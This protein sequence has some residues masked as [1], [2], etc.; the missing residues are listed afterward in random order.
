MLTVFYALKNTQD[1]YFYFFYF[2]L[3]NKQSLIYKKIEIFLPKQIIIKYKLYCSTRVT[4]LITMSDSKNFYANNMLFQSGVVSTNT[5]FHCHSKFTKIDGEKFEVFNENL[6]KLMN[7]EFGLDLKNVNEFLTTNKTIIVGEYLL[8]TYFDLTKDYDNSIIDFYVSYDGK[9]ISA[10]KYL[11]LF[12][13]MIGLDYQIY[14]GT[15]CEYIHF[16]EWNNCK[17]F[18]FIHNQTNAKLRLNMIEIEAGN[19]T[20]Y[21]V[22]CTD[23]SFCCTVYNGCELLCLDPNLFE[24]KIGYIIYKLRI[25]K[26]DFEPEHFNQLDRYKITYTGDVNR[27]KNHGFKILI[28]LNEANNYKIDLDKRTL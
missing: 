21:I 16:N 22:D 19:I 4:Q 5:A 23:Y 14:D 1:N 12:E 17:I 2:F 13:N 25:I 15:L 11:K 18:E 20:N 8:R 6:S 7:D 27:Y 26:C 3:Y 28:S 9:D 24:S 10:Y